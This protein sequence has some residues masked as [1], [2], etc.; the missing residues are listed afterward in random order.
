[1]QDKIKLDESSVIIGGLVFDPHGNPLGRD[2]YLKQVHI[3]RA[4]DKPVLEIAGLPWTRPEIDCK[5]C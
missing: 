4:K 5:D 2:P 3:N 1:M